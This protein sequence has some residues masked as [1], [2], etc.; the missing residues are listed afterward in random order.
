MDAEPIALV[1]IGCTLPGNVHGLDEMHTVLREGRDCV[2]E[3]P[4]SRWDV[5]ALYDPDP[6]AAGKTYVRHGG[7][8]DDV[9]RFDAAFFG[10]SDAEA[11][12]MDPQQR[13]L[14]QTVWHAMEHA[15]QN[16]DDLRGSN[17]GVFLAMMNGNNYGLLKRDIG[18]LTGITAFD[19][20]ADELSISAGR[21][22][23]FFD[24]KGPCLTVDTACS[25][26]LTALHLARQSIL[27]GECDSAV[28]AGVNLILNPDV[29]ISFC[30]LGLFS[31]SGQCRAFDAKADGYVR[32]EGCVA[33]LVRRQSLAEERG[34]PILASVVGTAINH[35]GRTPALTAPNGRTQ[36]DVIRAVLSR[37]GVDPA[38]VGYVEAHGTGTPVGDPIEM[39][40]IAGAYGHAHAVERPLYV[41]SVKSN[42]GHTEAAAG[43]LGVV[44]AALSLHH[45]VIYPSLHLDRLNPKID[46]N[47]T[48]VEVPGET[49]P[50]PRGDVP[51]LA[52]VNSFGYSGT[53][54]HAILREAPRVR[55]GADSARPRPAE[56]LVLSAKSPESLDGLADRWA[57][58]LSRADRE[59]LPA[60]LFTAAAGRAAHRH[61]LA[62]TGRGALGIANDLRLWRTR[63]TAAS[64]SSGHP[65][66]AART[67]F[68]FTGQGVQY[69]GMAR[70]LY[71]SEPDFA[72]AVDRCAE[73]LDDELPV[74]LR[75]ILFE[76]Q[77]PEALD[78]TRLAQPALFAVEYALAAL[79]RSWGAVPDAVVGHSI[80]EVAAACVA[81]MFSLEDAAR[82]SALRGRLMGEL[83]RDGAMLAVVADLG[84]VRGWVSG[85]EADVCVAAVNGP[86]A[87]VVSGRAE[88][89]AEVARRAEAEGSRTT[90]LRTSHAFHSP[91]MDPALP[92]LGKAAAGL[93][94]TAPTVPVFSNV[95]GEALTGAEGPEYWSQ[96]VRRPVRFHDGM[97]AVAALGCTVVVEIGP[98]PAL[99]A[100]VPEAF[101]AT[102]V[103]VIPT[104]LRDRRDVRNLLTTA[105]ALFTAGAAIEPAAL[106]RGPRHRRTSSAPQY[107][108]RKDRY[109]VSPAPSAGRD[110]P[111]EPAPRPPSTAA[112]AEPRPAARTVHRHEVRPGTPWVDHRILG[113]TVFPATG[114]LDLAV[115]AYASVDGHG[116]A[117]VELTDVGFVRPLLLSPAGPSG[118]QV[119]LEG[120]GP[121]ADGRFRFAVTGG[122][123]APRYCQG[124]VG[125][126]P[127]RSS[128]G[129]RPEELRAAMPTELAPGRLY[130]LLREDG[131]EYGASF[132]TVRELWLD[133]AGGQALG[134]ITA[135]PDGAR[136][137]S[138]ENPF[139][140]ML[141]GCLHLTAAAA[142]DGSARGT[143]IPVGVGRMVLRGPLPD[144]VW[145]HVRLRPNESG[146]A[147]TAHL[148]V[149]DDTGN[150]LADLEDVEFRRV[151]SLT[152]T[153]AV[154]AAPS[155]IRSRDG[156]DSRQE[157]RERVEPLPAE[158]RRQTVI[159][160]LTDE[161][162]DTLGR[163]STELEVDI[164]HLDPSLALLEIGLDSLSITE[165]Q[166]RIQEKLD[167][168]FKA[169]EALEYQSIE[170]LAEYL[171]HRVILAEATDAAAAPMDS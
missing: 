46:L 93:R 8:V 145:G 170:E 70:E 154:P 83:P 143:Y 128:P 119:D 164:H 4:P 64:V 76:E 69:P 74:P 65:A 120:D 57:D 32:S 53:N 129:T 171:L 88:A 10:I 47:G 27:T 138:H 82:F 153:S 168:R 18:G 101:G 94:P 162:A 54:A 80:G 167:F 136:R 71:G 81:G 111:A 139:A 56:L 12:R 62:V 72:A 5:D 103:T 38:Q 16:P 117:P 14:L 39:N 28:V 31:R 110:E 87:V 20:M 75:H 107:P 73:V 166:R 108:F 126:A 68:V 2:E 26:S 1:G 96:Q 77:S 121:A 63:R 114:Y 115:N 13:L 84:T 132:S 149:L 17:T 67:A 159:G 15:G 42:F 11:V 3:I 29:H 89:V 59:T 100:Y 98:H 36:E 116:S 51:R 34:D 40:A 131:M 78:D 156:G 45:E 160:W 137:V 9:D 151:A 97:R 102:E 169:M 91:L 113:S 37:T 50:W 90:R 58:H 85:R 49:V 7:F 55:P 135:A 33:A 105:G 25:G 112:P 118:L 61:R 146:S 141:D 99:R 35:D 30:K 130:G 92:E 104:L 140:T 142:R 148:R 79:L 23:H 125:P 86:R 124:K 21:I 48:A 44:K 52:G 106:H 66:K 109:W 123:G 22:A 41:G 133:E 152:D 158:E 165:L 157:L 24:L 161:I 95:T 60:A 122:D 43:L 134:R 147:F 155:D 6:L 144:Q 127:R 163:M 150:V 19:S